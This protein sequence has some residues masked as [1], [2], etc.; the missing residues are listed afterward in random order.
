VIQKGLKDQDTR[1]D[2]QKIADFAK[3]AIKEASEIGQ[4]AAAQ[5]RKDLQE[6]IELIKQQ[7]SELLRDVQQNPEG[8]REKVSRHLARLDQIKNTLM[9]KPKSASGGELVEEH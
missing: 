5:G 6:E 7:L 8:V 4:F 3:A 2:A 9:R 1:T